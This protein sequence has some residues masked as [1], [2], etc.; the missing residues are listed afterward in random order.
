LAL[1]GVL[2]LQGAGVVGPVGVGLGDGY[3]GRAYD[4]G[5][6]GEI[7]FRTAA[8]MV[9]NPPPGRYTYGVQPLGGF[10]AAGIHYFRWKMVLKSPSTGQPLPLGNLGTFIELRIAPCWPILLTIL[11]AALCWQQWA[12][13]RRLAR[14][15]F[16]CPH[17]GYDLR[18][19]PDRCPECG[20]VATPNA[21]VR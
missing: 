21:A 1:C 8:A 3:R 9:R 12:R 5:L 20:N 16:A 11:L 10:D 7:F 18:A 6:Q 13:R 17:C 14:G 2:A 15:Q 19:T 4:V